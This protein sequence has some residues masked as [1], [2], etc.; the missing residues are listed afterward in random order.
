MTDEVNNDKMI[1]V[2]KMNQALITGAVCSMRYLS[3]NMRIDV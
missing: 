2:N 3:V 1:V